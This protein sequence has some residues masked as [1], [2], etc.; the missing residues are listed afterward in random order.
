MRSVTD[1][2]PVSNA[3][4]SFLFQIVQLLEEAGNVYDTASTDEVDFAARVD[5]AGGEDV[6]VIGD[7]AHDNGMS[8][9]IATSGT[10]AEGGLLREDVDELALA[11]VTPLGP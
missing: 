8:S 1:Q 5:E 7:I 10:T 2:D 11:F 3:L 9:I 6:E 4:K